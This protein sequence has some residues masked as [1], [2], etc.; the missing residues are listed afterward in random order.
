VATVT[1]APAAAPTETVAELPRQTVIVPAGVPQ[2]AQA[3]QHIDEL[4]SELPPSD[5]VQV[6]IDGVVD[7]H[8]QEADGRHELLDALW[9]ATG[10]HVRDDEGAQREGRGQSEPRDRDGQQHVGDLRV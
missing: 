1:A 9:I 4:A 6:E 3:G 10:P 5:A 8:Q 7:V 2:G